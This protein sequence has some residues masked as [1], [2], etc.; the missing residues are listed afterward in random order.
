MCFVK[1]H[2]IITVFILHNKRNV[3]QGLSV[4]QTFLFWHIKL[5]ESYSRL[6]K[7]PVLNES[8][9]CQKHSI[10]SPLFWLYWMFF[11][12]LHTIDKRCPYVFA[13]QILWDFDISE[14]LVG[15]TEIRD[16]QRLGVYPLFFVLWTKAFGGF[17]SKCYCRKYYC[18]FC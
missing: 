9:L 17:I 12:L 6:I 3:L 7:T 15:Q 2:L 18:Y 4:W 14:R 8:F 16:S 1:V 11:R 13:F 5:C 10:S